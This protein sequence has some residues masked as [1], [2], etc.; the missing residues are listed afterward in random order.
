MNKRKDNGTFGQKIVS[1]LSYHLP[2]G[3]FGDLI[4]NKSMKILHKF[5]LL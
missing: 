3:K 4:L 1:F 2:C 5:K